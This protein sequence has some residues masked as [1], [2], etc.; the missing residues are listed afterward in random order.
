MNPFLELYHN[1][2]ATLTGLAYCLIL[3]SALFG[4]WWALSRNLLYLADH[5][6]D[7]WLVLV[8]FWYAARC[9]ATLLLIATDLL[10]VA[11]MIG[12]VTTT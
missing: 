9:I 3:L 11:A 6:R 2:V 1:P 5:W 4:T 12:V 8:P 10:L 7:G